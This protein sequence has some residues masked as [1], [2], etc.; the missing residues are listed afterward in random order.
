M[1]HVQDLK[2]VS[3]SNQVE[4]ASPI[5]ETKSRTGAFAITSV[6]TS[7][8]SGFLGRTRNDSNTPSLVY[9]TDKALHGASVAAI[10]GI[11]ANLV[12]IL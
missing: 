11:T 5:P 3:A 8:K 12:S 4:S 2:L 7:T 9:I 10:V 1:P 6:S